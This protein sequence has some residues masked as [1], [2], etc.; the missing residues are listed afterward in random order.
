MLARFT[1]TLQGDLSQ[2][3][4]L[5]TSFNLINSLKSLSE[6]GKDVN[7]K[8]IIFTNRVLCPIRPSYMSVLQFMLFL[9]LFFLHVLHVTCC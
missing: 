4:P 3:F 1:C 8:W 5:L 9:E 7:H 6:L 2:V